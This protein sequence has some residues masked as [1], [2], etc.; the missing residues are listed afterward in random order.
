MTLK[1]AFKVK[2]KVIN[3]FPSQNYTT[4]LSWFFGK[5]AFF[6]SY[7]REKIK[8]VYPVYFSYIYLYIYWQAF[9]VLKIDICRYIYKYKY[10]HIS[11]F[12]TTN[13]F[14]YYD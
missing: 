3:F 14:N 7:Q 2:F 10:L 5:N 12:G 11:I 13:A 6:S 1:N 4:F 8:I 9:V